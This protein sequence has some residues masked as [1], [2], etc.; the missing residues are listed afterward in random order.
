MIITHD[1]DAMPPIIDPRALD[2]DRIRPPAVD[3]EL[4][5]ALVDWSAGAV[6][7]RMITCPF[8]GEFYT[9]HVP[10]CLHLRARAWR[11]AHPR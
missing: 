2:D 1:A 10:D 3:A 4:F 5:E 8:F 11:E 7:G 9:Q 6:V